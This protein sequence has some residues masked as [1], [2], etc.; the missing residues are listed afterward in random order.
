VTAPAIQI[1]AAQSAGDA[2][3]AWRALR[4]ADDIQFTPVEPKPPPQSSAWLERV[5]DWLRE[6][7]EPL[8]RALG[9][10]WPTIQNVLIA[11]AI[12]LALIIMWFLLAPMVERL[13]VRRAT[14]PQEEWTPDRDAA[15]ALLADADR[16]AREGRYEEAVH[17]LL[18]R[19][20]ADI[21]EARPDWLLPASTA[22]E[23]A[24]FPRLPERARSAFGVIAVRVE[25]SLFA[26]RPLDEQD[27]SAARTAYADFA[28]ADLPR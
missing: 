3:G 1:A 15:A 23:I 16:L 19:S 17:L 10:S 14:K 27:W 18:R 2:T 21:A 25:R 8:G 6:L 11:L 12:L 13:R 20:V 9:M 5:G 7:L 26:L 24:Q 22:R 4:A 28:L